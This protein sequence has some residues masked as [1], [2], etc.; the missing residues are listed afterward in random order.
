MLPMDD[1]KQPAELMT[2]RKSGYIDCKNSTHHV[3][4]CKIIHMIIDLLKYYEQLQQR[5]NNVVQIQLYEYIYKHDYDIPTLMED[6]YQCKNNHLRTQDDIRC[7]KNMMHHNCHNSRCQYNRRYMRDRE[8]EI[9]VQNVET[10]TKQL[11]IMDQLD[12]IHAFIFHSLSQTQRN[13]G[14]KHNAIDVLSNESIF[15]KHIW[16]NKPPSIQQCNVDQISFIVQNYVFDEIRENYSNKLIPHKNEIIKYMKQHNFNGNKLSDS[17]R[18]QFAK[19]LQLHLNSKKLTMSLLALYDAT[20]K[21]DVSTLYDDQND[22]SD[23][24]EDTKYNQ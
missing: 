13:Q 4:N 12:S 19:E 16:S 15:T 7:I 1:K 22:N 6:W 5:T 23:S 8:R 17:S 18:K 2:L 24:A 9:Y 11:I 21:Y 14:G 3:K 10:D 20:V